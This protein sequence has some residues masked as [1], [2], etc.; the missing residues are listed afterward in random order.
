MIEFP[1][2]PKI[3]AVV[4]KNPAKSKRK[5]GKKRNYYAAAFLVA[6]KEPMSQTEA[7]KAVQVQEGEV[8]AVISNG[9]LNKVKIKPGKKPKSQTEA[10]K[11]AQIQEAQIDALISN[12]DF[13][14]VEMEPAITIVDRADQAEEAEIEAVISN[15]DLEMTIEPVI[16][17]VDCADKTEEAQFML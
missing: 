9:D 15:D 13:N 16:T 1:E 6:V 4:L 10:T 12:D 3:S 7:S 8:A 17:I 2:S 14:K 5:R 11:A